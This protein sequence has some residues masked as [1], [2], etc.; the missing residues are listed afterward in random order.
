MV[1]NAGE[2]DKLKM[3]CIWSRLMF[4]VCRNRMT[5]RQD[6]EEDSGDTEEQKL[7]VTREFKRLAQKSQENV[8]VCH[9]SCQRCH[10]VPVSDG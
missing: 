8:F 5:T 3:L 1:S 9:L 6:H 4:G 7:E 2:S 10:N